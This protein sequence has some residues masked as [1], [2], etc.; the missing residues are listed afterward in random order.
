MVSFMIFKQT[1]TSTRAEK[2]KKIF[3]K[4]LTSV[5]DLIAPSSMEIERDGLKIGNQF[6]RTLFIY[7]YPRYLYTNWLSPIINYDATIDISMFIYPVK[8]KTVMENLRKKVGQ[9][10]SSL[11]IE[12][13]KGKVRDPHLESA[14]KDAEML[15]DKL[16]L[17]TEKFFQ[18]SLYFTIYAKTKKELDYLTKEL[19]NILGGMLV[20]TKQATL[21]MEQGFNSTLPINSDELYIPRNLD[22]AS[23]ATCYPFTSSELTQNEGI[24]YGVNRYNNTLIIFDRFRLENANM[25]VFAKAGAGKSYAIKLEALRSL[26]LGTEMIVIDPEEEYKTLCQAI[27]GTY[28]DVSLTSDKRMNPFD[29]PKVIEKEEEK[30]RLRSAIGALHGLIN[31]MLSKLT[32]EEDAIMDRALIETY[33]L[34]DITF[35]PATQNKMPPLLP[36]LEEVLSNMKGAEGLTQRLRKYTQGTFSGLFSKP[37]NIDLD[38]KFIVFSLKN[39]EDVLRP[40]AMYMV[41]NYIWNRVRSELKKRIL[42]IDE[43]WNL[44]QYEDSAQ[45]IMGIAKRCRKYY[46]GLTTITQDVEDFLAGRYG[47]AIINNSSLQLLLKQS[48]AAIDLV[49][50]VFKLTEGEKYQ[51]LQCDIGDGI[52]FAGL[53]HV[54][55]HILASYMEDQ[56]ITTSPEQLLEIK[57]I[58]EKTEAETRTR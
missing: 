32:P 25:V 34:K 3:E 46:L 43:A 9:I 26:M 14:L 1:R 49:A 23:L 20:Y 27:G 35:D 38:N 51:L 40:I 48:P 54:A 13:E 33:G 8:S 58:R 36:D 19:E 2:A 6:I 50:D 28:V 45:F 12:A 17:G 37:T 5:R 16:Q 10:E 56:I 53:N 31:I 7:A 44:M 57:A 18:F 39:L 55:I 29:L 42:V 15:R 11:N 22:T 30:D 47:K 24:L 41:I 4:G 52:F 21:Q